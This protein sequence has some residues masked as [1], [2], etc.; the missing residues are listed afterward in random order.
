MKIMTHMDKEEIKPTC[1]RSRLEA[2][3]AVDG[4]IE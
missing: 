3:V 4:Y 2:V 1:S